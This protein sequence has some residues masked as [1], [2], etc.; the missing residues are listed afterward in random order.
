MNKPYLVRFWHGKPCGFEH[1]YT[2]LDEIC[3]KSEGDTNL[4]WDGSLSE[5]ADKWK[6]KFIYYPPSDREKEYISGVIW[7][8]PFGGFGQR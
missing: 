8:T 7:V 2:R 3:R 1:F 6:S 4:F 5:F